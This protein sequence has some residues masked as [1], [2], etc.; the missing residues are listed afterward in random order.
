MSKRT[1]TFVFRLYVA[2]D[3]HN[4]VLARANLRALCETYLPEQHQIEVLDVFREPKRA[5]EDAI[6]MTPTL[7]KLAPASVSR[8]VGT[9]SQTQSVL[10]ALGLDDRVP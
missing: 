3:A 6:F 5:L 2:G 7:I 4:S 9:L 1:P 8:I 10:L